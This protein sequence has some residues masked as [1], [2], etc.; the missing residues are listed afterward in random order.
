MQEENQ[1]IHRFIRPGQL[2]NA[3][4]YRIIALGTTDVQMFNQALA[5]DLALDA[6]TGVTGELRLRFALCDHDGHSYSSNAAAM[7]IARGVMDPPEDMGE[8]EVR[9]DDSDHDDDDKPAPKAKAAP[10]KAPAKRAPRKVTT[11]RTRAA[12]RQRKAPVKPDPK[13][14]GKARATPTPILISDDDDDD[15]PTITSKKGKGVR[16]TIPSEDDEEEDEVSADKQPPLSAEERFANDMAKASVA[17]IV[18]SRDEDASRAMESNEGESSA[19]A[20]HVPRT[21]GEGGSSS[22]L[23]GLP[24][25][26]S[27]TSSARASPF[28]TAT[29]LPNVPRTA[30]S[31]QGS[32]FGTPSFADLMLHVQGTLPFSAAVQAPLPAL[33]RAPSPNDMQMSTPPIV[34]PPPSD[35]MQPS[36]PFG[37]TDRAM[38][39]DTEMR[40]EDFLNS[41]GPDDDENDA[42]V[43]QMT[44]A[45]LSPRREG[46]GLQYAPLPPPSGEISRPTPPPPPPRPFPMDTTLPREPTPP[47][48]KSPAKRGRTSD[49]PTSDQPALKTPK[50]N[51]AVFG[52]SASPL[53]DPDAN[54]SPEDALARDPMP[55][56][57]QKVLQSRQVI[58][59]VPVVKKV[60]ARQ[61]STSGLAERLR[62]TAPTAEAST[63]GQNS[64]KASPSGAG[65]SGASSSGAG[66]SRGGRWSN[67]GS[68]AQLSKD[69]AAEKVAEGAKTRSGKG[70]GDAPGAKKR[71]RGKR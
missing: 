47:A 49:P 5:K 36:P 10:K 13:G 33:P 61:A 29:T 55:A 64:A 20:R 42:I 22:N 46:L 7:D 60:A 24:R 62:Q 51:T 9:S 19:A 4:A 34:T 14:K 43:M 32:R 8:D 16:V 41:T 21:A 12:P 44:R 1:A 2:E 38:V 58:A 35:D 11:T 37:M 6:F 48:E 69:L 70:R 65:P 31:M 71:G 25:H 66:P 56:K 18:T 57:P 67:L 3:V 40:I 39:K 23:A 63:S 59:A 52:G 50:L 17:S 68:G 28:A 30:R 54:G 53:S 27:E 26:L 45:S 15:E